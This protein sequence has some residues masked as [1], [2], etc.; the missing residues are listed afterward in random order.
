[1]DCVAVGSCAT[2]NRNVDTAAD[3]AVWAPQGTMWVASPATDGTCI[4]CP[5]EHGPVGFTLT[6]H[7]G[8]RLVAADELLAT[9]P[10]RQPEP[11]GGR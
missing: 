2:I 1:M 10:P 4:A 5:A 6:A 8:R 7:E 3:R 9:C 11:P